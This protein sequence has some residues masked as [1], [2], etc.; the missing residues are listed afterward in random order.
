M[1][2][3]IRDI[4][5]LTLFF[6]LTTTVHAATLLAQY[7]FDGNGVD[8]SGNGNHALFEGATG[9]TAGVSGQ[10]LS[11]NGEGWARVPNDPI[12]D[13]GSGDFTVSLFVAFY[14]N[15]AHQILVENCW[16]GCGGSNWTLAVFDGG[17]TS[18]SIHT[19]GGF[20]QS[21]TAPVEWGDNEFHNLVWSRSDNI[22]STYV[23]GVLVESY[24]STGN[25][26]APGIDLYIGSRNPGDGRD[27]DLYGAI[28]DLRLY[29]GALTESEID[30]IVN[31]TDIPEPT[32][33][34]VLALGLLVMS[35]FKK[36][37]A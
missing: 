15:P 24:S 18:K 11:L 6:T 30:A 27:F 3:I 2:I 20:N 16:G 35:R 28:D 23:D 22:F 31:Q 7:Q 26:S 25:L 10:A 19:N 32:P 12:F 14:N 13:F 33:L 36:C 34:L 5:A 4:L 21:T 9:F 8:S 29:S 37:Q 1:K 17:G